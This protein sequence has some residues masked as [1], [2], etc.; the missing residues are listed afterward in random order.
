[1]E[2]L[3]ETDKTQDKENSPLISM[4]TKR[5]FHKRK[6]LREISMIPRIPLKEIGD[7]DDDTGCSL[8]QV[9]GARKRNAN[10]R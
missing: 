6:N 7:N 2:C 5:V 1:M 3:N 9:L 4:N 10:I 8:G